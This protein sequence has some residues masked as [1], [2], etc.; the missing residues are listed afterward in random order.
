MAHR[1]YLSNILPHWPIADQE[2]LLDEHMP[3]WRR[4][5]AIYMDVLNPRKRKSHGVADL[6]ER[7]RL[8]RPTGRNSAVTVVVATAGLL[9]WS[10]ADFLTVLEAITARGAALRLLKEDLLIEPDAGVPGVARATAA[11]ERSKLRPDGGGPGVGGKI[12]GERREAA[13]KAKCEVVR[14]LWESPRSE[15][16]DAAVAQEAGVSLATIKTHLGKRQ[17][18]IRRRQAAIATAERNRARKKQP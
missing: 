13:A 8:L 5:P 18:A 6:T 11:F 1:I 10:T 12:S 17:D 7:A 16:T 4:S 14:S 3:G 9:A 2:V 15:I